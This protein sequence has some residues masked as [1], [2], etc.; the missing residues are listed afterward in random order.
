M[1]KRKCSVQSIWRFEVGLYP[2]TSLAFKKTIPS[3]IT[4]QRALLARAPA[5]RHQ[6]DPTSWTG[7]W[8]TPVQMA[9]R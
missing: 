3:V 4:P 1:F 8:T 9:L 2:G 5:G 7:P 6:L